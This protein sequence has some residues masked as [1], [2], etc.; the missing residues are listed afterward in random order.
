MNIAGVYS[1]N[2]GKEVIEQ[3]FATELN[4]IVAIIREVIGTSVK[5]L[6]GTENRT[7]DHVS[8][9]AAALQQAFEREF[10]AH[11]WQSGEISYAYPVTYYTSGYAPTVEPEKVSR[12]ID[13]I[14]NRLGVDI[15]LSG[16]EPSVFSGCAKMTIF[17]NLDMIDAGVEIVPVKDL[18]DEMSTGVSYFEQFV[19][20]LETRGVSNIDISVLILGV[21]P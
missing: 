4:E 2:R 9:Q 13:F 12:K 3:Q 19:W 21:S 7:P 14:K 15:H 20:D 10:L 8:R 11:H 16:P 1:F 18:A 6:I 5:D 17:H